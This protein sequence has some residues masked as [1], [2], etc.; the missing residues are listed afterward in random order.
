MCVEHI[1]AFIKSMLCRWREGSGMVAT[2][3]WQNHRRFKI[4]F[5]SYFVSF[6]QRTSTVIF[7][8]KIFFPPF[9]NKNNCRAT[10]AVCPVNFPGKPPAP[11]CPDLSFDTNLPL[12]SGPPC[13]PDTA[14]DHLVRSAGTSLFEP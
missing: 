8:P 10:L 7:F 6:L 14:G 9:L 11:G 2:S 13:V 4:Y 12:F 5:L 1:T 3:G